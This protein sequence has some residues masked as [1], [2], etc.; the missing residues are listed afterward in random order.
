[1]FKAIFIHPDD[2]SRK[3][4]G[5]WSNERASSVTNTYGHCRLNDSSAV[6]HCT[7]S[8]R[9]FFISKKLFVL[10]LQNVFFYVQSLLKFPK[11][12]KFLLTFFLWN[13][14]C[15][16]WEKNS[17]VQNSRHTQQ[18]CTHFD[19][20]NSDSREF[21]ELWTWIFSMLLAASSPLKHFENEAGVFR[22]SQIKKFYVAFEDM[23]ILFNLFH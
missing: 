7:S 13:S 15:E 22:R 9:F 10:M 19:T 1:M 17:F 2:K 12:L 5:K 20:Y 23:K 18:K 11:S 6:V 3:V 14:T 8:Y 4:R 21:I 16:M